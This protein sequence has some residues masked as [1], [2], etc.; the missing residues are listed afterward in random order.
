MRT[1]DIK[2]T[3]VVGA[4]T[5]GH[6]I[7]LNFALSGYRVMLCDVSDGILERAVTDM[8]KALDLFQDEGLVTG[9]EA[10]RAMSKVSVTTGLED[11]AGSSDFIT[12]AIV[13]RSGDKRRLFNRLDEICAPETILA[14]NTSWLVL[15]DFASEVKRQDRVI[16]THYFAPPHIVPGVEVC[17]GPGTS[18]ETYEATCRLMERTGKIPIRVRK[19]RTGHIINRLQDA[20]RHEANVLW[21]EG[22][23]SAEDIELGIVTTCGFRMPFEGSMKHFDIAGMWRWP[24]DV[25][26]GYAENEADESWGLSPELVRKIR[27]R[28]AEGK[29]WFLD[30]DR[31]EE[32]V[33]KR[34][35]D[36]IRRLK[37]LYPGKK[38]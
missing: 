22:V 34:D 15:S 16:I 18:A 35:R 10:E 23:A 20:M 38:E 5:M 7:A 28:Y 6:G 25:L 37:A 21:A 31:F 9:D 29:P 27:D 30:P 11:L 13:E 19:E 12:E 1:G 24:K 4:G 33:E 8:R 26:D 2:I 32:E 14:S 17:G 36:L 3:G